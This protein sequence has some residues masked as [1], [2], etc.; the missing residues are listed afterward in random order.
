MKKI[1]LLYLFVLIS[2]IGLVHSQSLDYLEQNDNIQSYVV[3]KKMFEMMSKIKVDSKDA[4]AQKYI[5]LLQKLDQLQVFSTKNVKAS[6][7]IKKASEQYLT[8][9]N[10]QELM[11]TNT[12][13]K[14]VKIF[15]K[16]GS[17][18]NEVKELL[19]HIEGSENILLLLKGTFGLDEIALLTEKMNI[20]GG[21]ELKKANKK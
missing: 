4:E 18:A 15:A 17:K 11:R 13:G 1:T 19:M 10:L 12:N 14:Q 20:P 16:Q 21:D 8:K 5:Q 9:N 6:E 3:N 7:E 2:N